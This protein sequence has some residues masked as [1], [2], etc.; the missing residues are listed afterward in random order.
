MQKEKRTYGAISDDSGNRY[1]L[2]WLHFLLND[3]NAAKTYYQVF[4]L[5]VLTAGALRVE[6]RRMIPNDL[7]SGLELREGHSFQDN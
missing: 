4:C 2:F 6:A 7:I 3:L 5:S 1:V